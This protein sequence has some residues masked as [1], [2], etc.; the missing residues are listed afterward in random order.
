MVL[1]YLKS[2]GLLPEW[3]ELAHDRAAWR[4]LVKEATEELNCLL[5]EREASTL[6]ERKLRREGGCP[7]VLSCS[8]L[9]CPEPGCGFVGQTKAGLVNHSRQRHG[10]GAQVRLPCPHCRGVFHKQGLSIHTRYCH[11]NPVCARRTRHI[12]LSSS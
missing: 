7:P 9:T 6:D 1:S 8:S 4:A 5:E 11:E 2:C 10:S 3:R 12:P